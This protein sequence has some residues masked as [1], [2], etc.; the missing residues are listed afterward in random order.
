[1][2]DAQAADGLEAD[3]DGRRARVESGQVG[4]LVVARDKLEVLPG[5]QSVLE[6]QGMKD[7]RLAVAGHE[8]TVYPGPLTPA[9]SAIRVGRLPSGNSHIG[10]P[11]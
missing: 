3:V 1:M 5:R 2:V 8:D 4:M 9:P 6:Q 7:G 11:A 10:G